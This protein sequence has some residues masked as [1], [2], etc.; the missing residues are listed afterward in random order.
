MARWSG[1]LGATVAGGGRDPTGDPWP[2]WRARAAPGLGPDEFDAAQDADA[3]TVGTRVG[4]RHPLVRSAVY[5]AAS[6][7]QCP[8]HVGVRQ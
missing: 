7:A 8:C 3:L 1:C 4:F 5:R 6:P 2:L